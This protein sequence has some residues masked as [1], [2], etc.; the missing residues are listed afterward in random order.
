MVLTEQRTD[1][2]PKN[3][4]DILPCFQIITIGN[5]LTSSDLK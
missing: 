4:V 3:A 2:W 5:N 1:G